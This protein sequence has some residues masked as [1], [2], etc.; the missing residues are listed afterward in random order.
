MVLSLISAARQVFC[1]AARSSSGAPGSR[2]PSP[3]RHGRLHRVSWPCLWPGPVGHMI[4]VHAAFLISL[5]GLGVSFDAAAAVQESHYPV[6]LELWVL[7]GIFPGSGG[8]P[9]VHQ[10]GLSSGVVL[11]P[12]AA[13]LFSSLSLLNPLGRL[14][15]APRTW[16]GHHAASVPRPT[17]QACP[18]SMA[19]AA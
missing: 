3:S 17:G 13:P 9:A 1:D 16:G 18:S 10:R 11:P 14:N 12:Y 19:Q 7:P 15:T 5:S 4:Q 6:S 2:R 8:L